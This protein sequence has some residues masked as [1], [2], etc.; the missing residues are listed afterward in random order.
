MTDRC[1]RPTL[2]RSVDS[3]YARVVA[4]PPPPPG[5]IV[6]AFVHGVGISGIERVRTLLYR[7]HVR[8]VTVNGAHVYRLVPA[9]AA[10]GL[11]MDTS[12]GL[13]YRAPFSLSPGVRTLE[14]TGASGRLRFDFYGLRVRAR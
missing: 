7:P 8:R 4:V 11:L 2:I 1:S 6:E 5:G 9:T 10:D 13:D 12:R 3:A 14:I